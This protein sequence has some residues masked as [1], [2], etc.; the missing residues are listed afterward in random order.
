MQTKNIIKSNSYEILPPE[1]QK[2]Q[3]AI[4][5]PE[6]QEMLKALAKY[7][8]GIAMPHKHDAV[9]GAFQLMEENEIQVET[10]LQVSFVEETNIDMSNYVPVGWVWN[11]N[12]IKAE[13]KCYTC[14]ARDPLTG[15]HSGMHQS[16]PC[17][18]KESA[19]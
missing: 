6:V 14:C 7:N 11:D 3:D 9:T 19:N 12:G 4:D 18:G 13:K 16:S 2:A 10:D 8:L 17:P 1:L 15:V 5:L